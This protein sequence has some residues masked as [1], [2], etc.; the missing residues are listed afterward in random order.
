MLKPFHSP[1]CS[2]SLLL[3]M[4]IPMNPTV[5]WPSA[6]FEFQTISTY[7]TYLAPSKLPRASYVRFIE[8]CLL[9]IL[10][11]GFQKHTVAFLFVKISH[12]FYAPTPCTPINFAPVNSF[13]FIFT[14]A[15]R[16]DESVYHR[17]KFSQLT[18]MLACCLCPKQPAKTLLLPSKVL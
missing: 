9:S 18:M 1:I 8:T 2:N 3:F 17:V 6:L 15:T 5:P 12:P 7:P 11:R 14:T 16:I 10:T 13:N 4:L